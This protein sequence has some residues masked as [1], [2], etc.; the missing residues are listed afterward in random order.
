MLFVLWLIVRL[1]TRLLVLSD[2]DDGSK[3]LE[4][5]VLR[6]QL[7]VL[8]RKTGRTRCTARDRVLLA[9]ASRM[10]PRQRWASLFRVTP[11]TLLRWHRSLV[12]RTWTYQQGAHARTAAGRPAGRGRDPADGE[13][14]CLV[15]LRAELRRAAASCAGS[16]SGWVPRPAGRC[17]DAAASA[18]RRDVRADLDTVPTSA[19][20]GDCGGRR[21]HGGDD[22]VH[23]PL[24]AVLPPAQHQ[25][26]RRGR[27]PGPPRHG[28]GRPAGKERRDGPG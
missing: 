2:A 18:R 19:G 24:R 6:H 28:L 20:R 3:D 7:G 8:R 27:G 5:L 15:G 4:I 9:A 13:G 17:C 23:G 22:P 12:R 26:D 1:L 11:R 14:E 25:A 16:A 21:V 10:L